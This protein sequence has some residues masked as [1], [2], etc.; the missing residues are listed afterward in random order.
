M[1]GNSWFT[2][3]K[4]LPKR[5]YS[6]TINERIRLSHKLCRTMNQI[7]YWNYWC[8]VLHILKLLFCPHEIIFYYKIIYLIQAN[9]LTSMWELCFQWVLEWTVRDLVYVFTWTQTTEQRKL[10]M[11]KN[12]ILTKT[13]RFSVLTATY[14][15]SHSV[16]NC[17]IQLFCER[18]HFNAVVFSTW[19]LLLLC[20]QDIFFS[21][22]HV[23]SV[24]SSNTM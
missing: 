15:K 3:L 7:K 10:I 17:P 24:I 9:G 22:V 12:N 5:N 11:V 14:I 2:N 18:W 19:L 21:R 8:D 20:L 16:S 6:N 23:V 1:K 13:F 4:I